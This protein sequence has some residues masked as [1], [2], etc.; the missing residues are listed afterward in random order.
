MAAAT[1]TA[2]LPM[3]SIGATRKGAACGLAFD[4]ARGPILAICGLT[5][6][7]GT[8]TLA[9]ALARQAAEESAM[10]VLLTETNTQTGSLA[11]L[12]GHVTAHSLATLAASLGDEHES[13]SDTFAVVDGGLRLIAAAPQP[14]TPL[15]DGALSDLL[16]Q[17]RD[18]HGL[19]VLDCGTGWALDRAAL[20][21]ATHI[22]WTTP[23]T[24]AG[25]ARA[26]VMLTSQVAPPAGRCREALAAVGMTPTPAASVRALRCL[27]RGRCE[28]L[29]LIPH[30]ARTASRG[31][32]AA[33]TLR[34]LTALGSFLRSASR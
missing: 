11:T 5:G 21:S 20:A 4:V 26:R 16:A 24:T 25:L 29:V 27:A 30:D 1:L 31:T 19:V 13:P 32:E 23:A 8:T 28:R 10:P 33:G 3:R 2:R 14:A 12:T 18:V 9:L 7:A 6:G 34:A 17:A 15:A 22:I